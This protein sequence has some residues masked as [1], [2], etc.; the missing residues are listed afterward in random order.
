MS[1]KPASIEEK[2]QDAKLET[3]DSVSSSVSPPPKLTEE[4]EA[5]LWRKIDRRL[6]PILCLMYLMSFLDRGN[7]G[8]FTGDE[9]CRPFLTSKS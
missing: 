5:K 1:P 9:R 8:A 7:I 2:E 6:M 3:R 4:Q